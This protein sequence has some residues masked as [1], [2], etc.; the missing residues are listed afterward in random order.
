MQVPFDTCLLCSCYHPIF[1]KV[2]QDGNTN[3]YENNQKWEYLNETEMIPIEMN[4]LVLSSEEVKP[5]QTI[6]ML[7]ESNS[8]IGGY[9]TWWQQDAE[10]LNCVVCK[11]IMDFVGQID[12]ADVEKYSDGIYYFH[13]CKKCNIT[14]TNFQCG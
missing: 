8:R 4:T 6:T 13:H 3:W 10:F 1:M 14:G 5:E 12:M 2:A 7:Q 9:P 11:N